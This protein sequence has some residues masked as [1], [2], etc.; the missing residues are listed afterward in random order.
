MKIKGKTLKQ[1]WRDHRTRWLACQRC[2]FATFRD[3]LVLGRGKLPADVLFVGEGPGKS[4]DVI[5]EPFIGPAGKLL[6]RWIDESIARVQAYEYAITNLVA[7]RPCNR[8]SGDNR[9]PSVEEV[10]NCQPRLTEIMYMAQP[11]LI[12]AIGRVAEE[13]LLNMMRECMSLSATLA[14]LQ[15]PAFVLRRGGEG[16]PEDKKNRDVLTSLIKR[17][18]WSRERKGR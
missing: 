18:I 5:G 11:R 15:H 3:R 4:E 6:Q 17:M 7:C 13:R 8:V 16:R 9:M 2:A 12:I 14:A 10:R 1:N